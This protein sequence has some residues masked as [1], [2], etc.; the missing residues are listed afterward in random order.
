MFVSEASPTSEPHAPPWLADLNPEQHAAAVHRDGHLLVLAGA[1]TG[2]TTT[3]CARVAWLIEEGVAPERIL[4]LTFTRRAAREMLARAGALTRSAPGGGARRVVGGTFHA[5][6]HRLVRAHAAALGLAQD[7]ALLDAADA[8]DL[9]DLV[10]QEQ[11]LSETGRRFP[12]KH[13]LAD[14]CSRTVNAQRPLRELLAS[15]FPWCEEHGDALA[16]LFRAFAA[17]KRELGVLD[18]DDLLLYWRALVLDPAAGRHIAQG[19]DHVLVDEY[20]DVNGL[21]VDI[22]AG[23]A[24]HGCTVT[25][26][27]NDFQA[28]YGFRS[29]SAGHILGFP[30]Q[31]AGAA[32]VT[33]ERNY[34]SG[35]GLLDVANAVAAQDA[36]GFPKVLRA[37]RGGGEVPRLVFCRDQTHEAAEV[38][39]RVL[40]AR[41]EGM[42]LREQA[43]LARTGHDTDLLELEL[44]RRRIPYVKYGGLRYLEAAHVKDFLAVLRLTDRLGDEM[45]WF[46]VL[47]LL[48]GVGPNRAR[49]ALDHLLAG[50]P[51]PAAEL[52]AR[53]ETARA[54]LPSGAREHGDALVA[55]LAGAQDAGAAAGAERLRDA[56]APLV[57]AK[58]PDGAVRLQDLDALCGLAGEA[59]DLRTFVAELVIDPPSSSS[60]LAV[61]P[62]LDDDWLVLSTVHSA[63]G[64]EWQSV[65]VIAA[66]DGNFPA[67]MAVGTKES[68]AEERRLLYVALTRARRSLTVYVP[69]RYYHRPTGRDDG[70]GYGK[71]SRFLSPD[72]QAL[73]EVVHLADDPAAAAPVPAPGAQARITVSVDELFA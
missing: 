65:H 23:L 73:C 57:R 21:Q 38:C 5:A 11:G 45:S 8:A 42:L 20:Q 28:I 15:D 29:A 33:L 48:E 54:E 46:R 25:A 66:Y 59:A 17:R 1:G 68:I 9:L 63:K 14:L 2:K 37:Q 52:P 69:R 19:I 7:F 24:D 36:D 16:E 58:Y 62:H 41:E 60:D 22:V 26:V 71:A 27:G 43:V 47:L 51:P 3:V 44:S 64:L 13:T 56:L 50:G 53:W 49:R 10:R 61:A 67:C 31:F 55:A 39:D 6:A 18:L 32:T 72:V 35:Q 40:A 70:H 4:L 12:R 30:A 34:R